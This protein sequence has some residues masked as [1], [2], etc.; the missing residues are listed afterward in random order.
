[1]RAG[2][3][4]VGR[5]IGFL[6][7]CRPVA[8]LVEREVLLLLGRAR[9]R[10]TRQR[11]FVIRLEPLQAIVR[12]DLVLIVGRVQAAGN[13]PRQPEPTKNYTRLLKS[14]SVHRLVHT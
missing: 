2:L 6:H 10:G 7:Q 5:A 1:M 14:P 4:V 11:T 12:V 9:N 3:R 13:V 8:Q